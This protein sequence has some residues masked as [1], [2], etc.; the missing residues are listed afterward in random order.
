MKRTQ[1]GWVT[2][3]IVLIVNSIVIFQ[4]PHP[5]TFLLISIISLITILMFYKLTI[6]VS[7]KCVQYSFGIGLI[8]GSYKLND[9]I[10]CKPISYMPLGWG[11]RFRPGVILYNVSGNKAIELEVKNKKRK[12]WIGTNVPEELADYINSQ[13]SQVV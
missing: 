3:T 6:T 11:I 10:S 5:T 4:F 7:E 9:I 8:K 1:F 13:R 2:V 12:I